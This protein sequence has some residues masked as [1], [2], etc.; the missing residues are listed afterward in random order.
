MPRLEFCKDFDIIYNS[1][2]DGLSF[3]R[4]ASHIIGYKGPFIILVKHI[5]V[6]DEESKDENSMQEYVLGA[7]INNELKDKAKY[8]GDLNSCIFSVCPDLRV[9]RTINNK[10]GTNYAYL[11]T[12]KIENSQYPYGIGFGGSNV[13]FRFWLDGDNIVEKSYILPTDNTYEVGYI[14]PNKNNNGQLNISKIEIYGLGGDEAKDAQEEHKAMLKKM[15]DKKKT[16][17][18][19]AFLDSDFDKEFLLGNT[20]SHKREIESKEGR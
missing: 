9:M 14:I 10:G 17:D 16:V 12:V 7:F 4:L 18:K 13:E 3:N 19:K 2:W 20:F 15:R 1:S 8:L 5:E 6:S 11:N